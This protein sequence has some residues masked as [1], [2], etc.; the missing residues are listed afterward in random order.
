MA[1]ELF[2]TM[3]M[4]LY[5]EIR[6]PDM[7][8]ASLFTVRPGNISDTE[9]VKIDVV[10]GLEQISPVVG[11]CEG[12]TYNI[13]DQF[14]TK[15]WTPPSIEEAMPFDCKEFLRRLPGQNEY[16]AA[17]TG[18]QA[19]LIR[20]I[21][22]GARAMEGK[23]N[24]N[25]DWQASQ[26]LQTGIVTLVDETGAT[27]YQV[28]FAPKGTHFVTAGTAWD[29]AGDPFGD[30]ESMSDVIRT[31]SLLDADQL[32]MGAGTFEAFMGN[33]SVQAQFD[34]RRINIGGIEPRNPVPGIGGKFQGNFHIGNYHYD[35]WTYNG[36]GIIPGASTPTKF[37][38]AESCIVRA[39]AGRLDTVFA[40]VPMIVSPDPRFADILPDRIAIPQAVDMA[41]NIWA[42]PNGKQVMLEIA[43]RPLCIPTAIDSFGKINSGI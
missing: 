26:L 8:L 27:N 9:K 43:S 21:A 18:Y 11:T 24:R 15:E 10:R 23:I 30:I 37:V 25:R 17:D 28:N 34:N 16:D 20:R 3:F 6:D 40:G 31:D 29:A 13:A 4:E 33:A 2:R 14:T 7:F 41:P 12:P 22:D 1:T 42:Q 36:Q 38:A 5:R 39:S 35:L 32:I 19:A